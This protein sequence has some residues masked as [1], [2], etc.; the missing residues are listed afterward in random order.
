M[1]LFKSISNWLFSEEREELKKHIDLKI[2]EIKKV[3]VTD[4]S[5]NPFKSVRLL[6]DTIIVVFHDGSSLE[7]T[8]SNLEDFETVKLFTNT[9]ELIRF[10]INSTAIVEEEDKEVDE[11]VFREVAILKGNPD[12]IIDNTNKRV[13][14]KNINLAIPTVIVASFVEILEKL[15][16]DKYNQEDLKNSY[17]AL[18]MFW[19]K[20]AINPIDASRED[21]LTFIKKNDVHITKYGNM[22]LY[23]RIVTKNQKKTKND[24]LK[25]ISTSY[26]S[27]KKNKKSP[28]KYLV[29]LDTSNKYKICKHDD[30][31]ILKDPALSFVGTLYDLYNDITLHEENVYTST[32][33]N[34]VSIKIG[35]VYS[36]P[37]DKINLN[38]G[39]CHAGGLHAAAVNYNYSGYGDTPVV[40]LVSPSKA[41]TVPKSETGKLRTTEMFIVCINNKSLGVHFDSNGICEFDEKYHD[42][43]LS[44][45]EEAVKSKDFNKISIKDKTP[46]LRISDLKSI[47]EELKNRIVKI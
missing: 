24:Y 30:S 17:E 44:Q 11:K 32:H 46:E 22:V 21:I 26:A 33:D 1:K 42:Y 7:K 47:T 27:V 16:S 29:Y 3:V 10:M 38:N 36:I 40:V 35:D 41:I 9:S 13:F 15:K 23:R 34:S 20:L 2:D 14:F 4:T 12:F 19:L 8:N 37:N 39:I 6:G 45:L 31:K 43:S 18:V 28:K 5:R 25:L